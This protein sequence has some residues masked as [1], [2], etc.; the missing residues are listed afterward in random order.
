MAIYT[1]ASVV[2]DTD[3]GITT[4][5]RGEDHVKKLSCPE[6]NIEALGAQPLAWDIW[7]A[8]RYRW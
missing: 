2:D 3:H 4:I 7:P 1:L 8:G 5:L 6:L